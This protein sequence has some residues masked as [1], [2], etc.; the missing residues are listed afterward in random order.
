MT[1]AHIRL[2]T[3]PQVAVFTAQIGNLPGGEAYVVENATGTFRVDA[4]SLLGMM[5]AASTFSNEMYLVNETN[6]GNFP[7]FVDSY[8]AL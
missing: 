5:Y 6:D 1:R 4:K 3:T 7:V 2:E 8:R